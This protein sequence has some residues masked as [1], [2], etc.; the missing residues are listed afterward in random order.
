MPDNDSR[1]MV[2]KGFFKELGL[3]IKLILRLM[4]DPRISPF[5]KALPIGTLVYLVMPD[6]LPGI[7]FDDAAVIG[8]GLYLFVELCPQSIVEEHRL[9]LLREMQGNMNSQTEVIDG[10]FRDV[11][12]SSNAPSAGAGDESSITDKEEG[13]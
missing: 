5:L 11:S 7:P 4:G 9:A 6:L 10:K 8:L 1:K 13:G 12:G 2:P 3:Q